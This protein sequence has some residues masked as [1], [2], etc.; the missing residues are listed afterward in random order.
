MVM[1]PSTKLDR[2]RIGDA[3]LITTENEADIATLDYANALRECERLQLAFDDEVA[4]LH[5]S[6]VERFRPHAE[7]ANALEAAIVAYAR[8]GLAIVNEGKAKLAKTFQ[9]HYARV[10]FS[11]ESDR[12]VI[13]VPTEVLLKNLRRCRLGDLIQKKEYVEAADLRTI[14]AD[15]QERVGFAIEPTPSVGKI[16]IDLQSLPPAIGEK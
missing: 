12:V 7:R 11:R 15:L 6:Y 5:A 13:K 16:E 1:K 3:V 8:R 10:K 14:R 9:L 4:R 2:S